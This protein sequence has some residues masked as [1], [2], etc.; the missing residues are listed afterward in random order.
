MCH[1]AV[2]WWNLGGC[3]KEMPKTILEE[4]KMWNKKDKLKEEEKAVVSCKK[5]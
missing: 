5:E 1:H 3:R 4:K 2:N